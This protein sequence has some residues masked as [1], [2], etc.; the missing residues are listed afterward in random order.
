MRTQLQPEPC[1]SLPDASPT[2]QAQLLSNSSE[3]PTGSGTSAPF[4]A[5]PARRARSSSAG[6]PSGDQQHKFDPVAASRGD[7]QHGPGAGTETHDIIRHADAP[8]SIA[9]E[10]AGSASILPETRACERQGA[11]PCASTKNSPGRRP[12]GKRGSVTDTAAVRPSGS[13]NKKPRLAV[14]GTL[15]LPTFERGRLP[16]LPVIASPLFFS[17]SPRH[18]FNRTKTLPNPEVIPLTMGDHQPH[19]DG[20]TTTRLPKSQISVTSPGLSSGMPRSRSSMELSSLSSSSDGCPQPS[21]VQLLGIG[22]VELLEQDERPTFIL[23]LK[24]SAHLYA[25]PLHILYA[26]FALRTAAGLL[27]LLHLDATKLDQGH[28]Y[29]EF[30]G[31]ATSLTQDVKAPNAPASSL[32]YAGVPW[33]CSTLGKRFRVIRGYRIAAFDPPAL[34]TKAQIPPPSPDS[35]GVFNGPWASQRPESPREPR[36]YFGQTALAQARSH[37]EPRSRAESTTD[38][39]IHPFDDLALSSPLRTTFDWTQIPIDDPNLS[40]HH[41]FARSID[42]AS[43][44][45]GPIESWPAELRIMSSMIMGSPY[46][47]SLH[48]GP[49]YVAIYNEAYI[50]LAGRKHPSLMGTRYRD[51]WPEI[52]DEIGPVFDAAW[53]SGHATMK[54]DDPLFIL[55]HGFSEETFFDWAVIPLVGGNGD[56]VAIYNPAFENT[57]RRIVERRMLALREVGIKT[58]EAR[59]VKSF[60]SQ[61]SKGLE[62]HPKDVPFALVYSVGEDNESDIASLQSGN[63]AHP[64][65]IV[66]EGSIG[67]PDGHPCATPLI[68]LRCSDEGFAPY[69]REAMACPTTPVVLSEADGTL[70]TELIQGLQW[71]GFGDACR[72]IVVFPVYPT[73]AGDMAVGFIVLGINPRRP[74]DEDY[75]LFVN[76]LSRQLATSLASVVL[77]EEEIRRGQMAARLAALDRQELSMQLHLRTQEAMESEYRFTRM[78]EFGPV[79][80]FIADGHGRINYCNEMWYK[81]SGL[82]RGANTFA[83]WMQS[84]RREDRL[85]TE[86]A[87]RRVVEEKVAVTHEFR[88]NNATELGDGH[89]VDLWALMSAYPEKDEKGELKSIFGCITDISQQKWAERVQKQHRDE[90]VELKRQ[91]E[92]FIDITSH[93]MRNPLSAIVQCAEEISSTLI[94]CTE[95]G[96]GAETPGGV[97]ALIESCVKAAGI[98]THCVDHQQR[99]MDDILLLSKLDSNLVLV[100]PADVQPVTVA[101]SVLKMFKTELSYH[102]IESQIVI[103]QSYRDLAVNYVKLDPSR[104]LQVLTN[105]MTNAIRVTQAETSRSIV[106]SV[107]ASKDISDYDFPYISPHHEHQEDVTDDPS[108]TD[109]EKVNLHF[110]ITDTGPGLNEDDARILFLQGSQGGPRTHSTY[111]GQGLGLF[112][113]RTLIELQGGQVAVQSTAGQGSTFAFY[114]KSR[115]SDR[116]VADSPLHTPIPTIPPSLQD[117]LA[118]EAPSPAQPATPAI[119]ATHVPLPESPSLFSSHTSCLDVLIVEDN[120][121]NQKVLKRQLDLAGSTTYVANH[122][123]EALAELQSSRFWNH[124]ADSEDN[125]DVLGSL[126]LKAWKNIS[127]ILMD[128]EM[129]VMDGIS[130]TRKIRELEAAGIITHHI[131]IIAVTA[132]ARP[133]QVASAKAAGVDGVIFKPF[134]MSDLIPKMRE[135]VLKSIMVPESR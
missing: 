52:W 110:S 23:D 6:P 94:R 17:S 122:G 81:I 51:A 108:W 120:L 31:W 45:L 111:G 63:L 65:K 130:C 109:G 60:W 113:C 115:R 89:A 123:G 61:V 25:G 28:D 59:D 125:P 26:N 68:D 82:S 16:D 3:S 15:P 131:P 119:D 85:P 132:Y 127:V 70:P 37:S 43:T 21:V 9:S 118:D 84:I 76:L 4:A 7:G 98:I 2:P 10:N 24:D 79:G 83:A 102:G 49:D 124:S 13:P 42:W 128:L 41:R 58:S 95:E 33:T 22:V 20:V 66:L 116:P 86:L 90:A 67:V 93:E 46:P 75:E 38:T 129:P 57:R 134:R 36:D 34:T 19:G 87:W 97:A 50:T 91:Q 104:L 80:L 72:N 29:A 105:L 47:A 112:I 103:D 44:P 27:N 64:P 11:G 14:P 74:Y 40:A 106:I 35:E 100:K 78:A 12:S 133:E 117:S 121:V 54:H 62:C 71:V 48:W 135:L 30:K 39:I 5:P 96:M 53:N 1:I 56:V 32:T 8:R 69:I 18:A 88:F 101:E 55:R 92:N 73:T 107:G 99:I 114:I 126:E 77:F